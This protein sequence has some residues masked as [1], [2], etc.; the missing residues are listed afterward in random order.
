MLHI[1]SVYLS[2]YLSICLSVHVYLT[3][4]E[5]NETEMTFTQGQSRSIFLNP[6]TVVPFRDGL[7][8]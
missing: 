2:I 7:I 1:L 6:F 8:D 3:V 4:A 5:I